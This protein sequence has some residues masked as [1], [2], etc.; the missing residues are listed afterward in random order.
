MLRV[1]P[2]QKSSGDDS[3]DYWKKMTV[4]VSCSLE[5]KKVGEVCSYF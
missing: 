2:A 1:Q 3:L 5:M 4:P